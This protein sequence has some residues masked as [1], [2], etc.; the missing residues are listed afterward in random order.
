MALRKIA[1]TDEKASVSLL[2][3]VVNTAGSTAFKQGSIYWID[4]GADI[5]IVSNF[6][7][8]S[9]ILKQ[10]NIAQG[11]AALDDV[12]FMVMAEQVV[13]QSDGRIDVVNDIRFKAT[14][15]LVDMTMTV[16]SSKGFDKSGN[17][18]ITAKRLN[19]GLNEINAPFV[20]AMDS[21]EFD[22]VNQ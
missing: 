4:V 12:H 22:I 13:K 5:E 18:M 9:E 8:A 1:Y 7:D 15:N 6:V 2:N 19:K 16:I 20:V 10:L 14:L 3:F 21:L 11:K 17:Y